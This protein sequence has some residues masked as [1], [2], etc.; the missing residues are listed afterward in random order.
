MTKKFPLP[1][2]ILLIIALKFASACPRQWF[3]IATWPD[4]RYSNI[5]VLQHLMEGTVMK[6]KAARACFRDLSLVFFMPAAS[7]LTCLDVGL[8]ISVDSIHKDHLLKKVSV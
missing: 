4:S 2:I 6:E 7:L 8:K 1:L 5:L 3:I